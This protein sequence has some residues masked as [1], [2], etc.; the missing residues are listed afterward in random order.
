MPWTCPKCKTRYPSRNKLRCDKII[1]GKVC[2]RKQPKKSVPAHRAVLKELTYEDFVEANGGEFCWICEYLW[3]EFGMP[4]VA[5]TRLHRDHDHKT[6]R[7]RG[8]LCFHHNNR[9][10]GNRTLEEGK[11][12]VAYLERFG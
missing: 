8:L 10:V 6:G 3:R 4:K 11:A 12:I 9:L 2:G 5:Y 1:D 7:P